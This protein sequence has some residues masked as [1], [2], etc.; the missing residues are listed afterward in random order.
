MGFVDQLGRGLDVMIGAFSPALGMRRAA[1]R[2]MTERFSARPAH[3][4]AATDRTRKGWRTTAGSPDADLN[5]DELVTLR[6]RSRDR[7]RND[8][9][10]SAAINAVVDNVV[11]CG[12]RPKLALNAK[13]LGITQDQADNLSETA[14]EIWD[15]W[16]RNCE[17]TGRLTIEEVQAQVLASTLTNGDHF[18]APVMLPPRWPSRYELALEMIEA[19]RVDNPTGTTAANIRSGIELNELGAP[20]AYFVC[21][22]HP[23]DIG[24]Q[25]PPPGVRDFRRIPA[26]NQVTPNR[27]NIL[28]VYTQE[29]SGQSR[30]RPFLSTV[31]NLF[32]DL[33]D[34]AETEL[35]AAQVAA[36]FSVFV[37]KNDP[38]SAMYARATAATK[39]ADKREEE[40]AP[41]MVAYLAPGEKI[42]TANPGRPNGTFHDY[43]DAM[44]RLICSGIG[45]P[46]EVVARNFTG[47]TYSNA[48]AVLLEARR[49]FK[50]R[51]VWLASKLL[52]PV[53]EM[54]LEEAW[55]RGSFPAPDKMMSQF[56]AWTRTHWIT[57]GWGWIDPEKEGNAYETALRLGLTTRA[58]IV[59]ESDGDDVVP[60]FRQLSREQ[61]LAVELGIDVSPQR[62]GASAASQSSAGNQQTDNAETPAAKQ[63]ATAPAAEEVV[64]S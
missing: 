25:V 48:R 20:V 44:C 51:Q 27:P 19:D 8:G 49:A 64:V 17:S 34:Y 37:T 10:A 52:Q 50:R 28:H 26:F 47:S 12:F 5:S 9:L 57:P 62:G 7:V 36:C 41:G 32:R 13:A 21:K 31:L 54:L 38:W 15:E 59:A 53:W 63:T 11:G 45:V 60:V 61:K 22:A 14:D 33:D 4:G 55:L 43:F 6:E 40:V 3:E 1:M 58:K 24:L 56:A 35:I 29:R 39:T 18:V 30:G 16:G 23:G 42:E 46:Y 2:K